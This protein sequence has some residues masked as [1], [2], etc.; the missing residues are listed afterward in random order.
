V[1]SATPAS[2]FHAE[3]FEPITLPPMIAQPLRLSLTRSGIDVIVPEDRSILEVLEENLVPVLASCRRGVCGT[4]E[5][6]V[7]G[8]TPQHRD[9]VLGLD[10]KTELGIM[11]PCVSR[12]MGGHLTL[13]V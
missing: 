12:A 10:E 4:C 7:T 1:E 9:S 3:H 8:G 2:R 11:F 5:V 6:R 13:D